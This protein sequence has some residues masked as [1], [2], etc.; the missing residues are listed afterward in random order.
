MPGPY[1]PDAE[2]ITRPADNDDAFYMAAELRTLKVY[3]AT[4]NSDQN[5]LNSAIAAA[6]SA[7]DAL[8]AATQA[9]AAAALLGANTLIQYCGLATGTANAIIISPPVA[10]TA[11]VP[12]QE[13]M[14]KV[15]ATNTGPTSVNISSLGAIPV[16]INGV[17][18]GG[19]ELVIGK[20]VRVL[21]DSTATAAQLLY[22][23][24][25]ATTQLQLQTFT[26]FTTAGSDTA[27]TL[28]PN[29]AITAYA[30]GQR[31]RI[32][33]HA[34]A[35]VIPTIAVSGLAVKNL[36]YY[37]YLGVKTSC[38]ATIIVANMLTDVEYDGV[39]FIVLDALTVKAT[40]AIN[41]EISTTQSVGNNT[42]AIA[43]TAFC[44][45]GFVNNDIG[46]GAPG[47]I[48][49]CNHFTGSN[50]TDNTTVAGSQLYGLTNSNP[51]YMTPDGIAK[52]GTWRN[53]TGST[54][55]AG[56]L[57]ANGSCGTFQRIS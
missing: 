11:L 48:A 12:G 40:D 20:Y 50:V 28:T 43:T 32:K 47:M 4:L 35:G 49:F 2:E 21:V 10:I 45:T 55:A 22:G 54:V 8:A 51:G 56:D 14:F 6:E 26:A 30:A 13:F 9:I 52:A 31:F 53:I 33:F 24:L 46:T 44:E 27:Y 29:P 16:Q 36:K 25:L 34:T 3:I 57:T 38:G 7:V 17:A 41:A 1:T 42:T 37:N 39:D 23:D 19:G 18:L 5:A 15:T